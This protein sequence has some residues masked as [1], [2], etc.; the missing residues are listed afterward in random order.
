M[1]SL[2]FPTITPPNMRSTYV[3][4]EQSELHHFL[5][6]LGVLHS[7]ARN[8]AS[9]ST[10]I[11]SPTPLG[12]SVGRPGPRYHADERPMPSDTFASSTWNTAS[13]PE[14]YT[15]QPAPKPQAF[16]HNQNLNQHFGG[17]GQGYGGFE[18]REHTPMRHARPRP[19]DAGRQGAGLMGMCRSP[20]GC[21]ARARG[22]WQPPIQ[23]GPNRTPAITRT[24]NNPHRS[25]RGAMYVRP[26]RRERPQRNVGNAEVMDDEAEDSGG[27]EY[28][29]EEDDQAAGDEREAR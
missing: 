15:A 14:Y 2:D 23:N 28:V 16:Q 27:E 7:W 9:L 18:Y 17:M 19:R 1:Y 24:P 13:S 6:E 3:L 21:E 11:T 5:H 29:E 22:A 25:Q 12:A 4:I 20:P 8:M 10:S 26:P